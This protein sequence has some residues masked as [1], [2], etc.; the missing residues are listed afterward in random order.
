[1]SEMLTSNLIKKVRFN[2]DAALGSLPKLL[3]NRLVDRVDFDLSQASAFDGA[4]LT[5]LRCLFDL[6]LL[7]GVDVGIKPPINPGA[8]RYA[9]GMGLFKGFPALPQDLFYNSQKNKFIPLAKITTDKNDFLLYEF[10]KLFNE[11]NL[12]TT[13]L[14]DA[15]LVFTEIA[16]NIFFHSGSIDDAGWGYL[17]AQIHGEVLKISFTDVGV[18]FVGAYKRSGTDKG[19]SSVQ[20]LIDSFNHLESRLNKPGGKAIRGIGLYETREFLKLSNGALDIKSNGAMIRLVGDR[21]PKILPMAWDF[22]GTQ[23]NLEVKL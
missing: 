4:K 3:V 13:S 17:Q 14:G 8:L 10:R 11:L 20:L 15:C 21:K 1:M 9:A 7:N 12:P 2:E 19:R 23:V 18:G 16:D 22:E 5:Q 6:A